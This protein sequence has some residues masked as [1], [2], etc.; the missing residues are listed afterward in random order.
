MANKR[1]LKYIVENLWLNR[2][3]ENRFCDLREQIEKMKDQEIK[4]WG[5][6]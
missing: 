5:K 4:L 3:L 6:S 2:V 1:K